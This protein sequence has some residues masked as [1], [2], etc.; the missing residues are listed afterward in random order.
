[1]WR[2]QNAGCPYQETLRMRRSFR[3]LPDVQEELV[4]QYGLKDLE[5]ADRKKIVLRKPSVAYC[6]W[7][8]VLKGEEAEAEE[9]GA[10]IAE[11]KPCEESKPESPWKRSWMLSE[12]V[13]HVHRA[14][15]Y[16]KLHKK[17][18]SLMHLTSSCE[19]R[20]ANQKV[21]IPVITYM[22]GL[23]VR[24]CSSESTFRP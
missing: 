12:K 22:P 17:S 8:G 21:L 13:K 14:V 19:T 6:T 7:G 10:E 5:D 16:Q 15:R 4:W 1:M 18:R 20:S 3:A 23:I 11:E 9:D 24:S 2:M